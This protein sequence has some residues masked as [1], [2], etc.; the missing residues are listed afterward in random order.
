MTHCSYQYVEM[1]LIQEYD[2]SLEQSLS[3][4]TQH[5]HSLSSD[6]SV[7]Q[8]TVTQLHTQLQSLPSTVTQ[9]DQ[10]RKSLLA[11]EANCTEVLMHT[12]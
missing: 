8:V 11:A 4:L 7:L 2:R 9:L 3:E 5:A 12:W 1:L 6:N 10:L